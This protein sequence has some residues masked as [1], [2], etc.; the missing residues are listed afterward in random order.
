M[1]KTRG[2]GHAL[3]RVVARGLGEGMVMI[4]TVLPNVEGRPHWHA[5]NEYLSL[6]TMLCLRYLWTHLRDLSVLTEYVDHV[7]ANER[8]ELKLSSHGRKVHNLG[9]PVPAIEDMSLCTDEAMLLLVELLMVSAD[10]AMVETGQCGG[11]YALRDLILAGRYAWGAA[12]LVHMYDQLNNAS[13]STSRQLAVAECNADLDYDE[14]S[15]RTCRWIATKKTV[16][17]VSTTTYRQRLDRLRIPDVCWMPYAE[18]RPMQYF[19]PISCFSGQLRWGLLLSDTDQRGLCASSTTSNAFLHTL[20][21]HRC[22]M[23][24]WTIRGRTTQTIWQQQVIYV[25]CQEACHAIMEALEQHLNAPGTSTH[26]EVI[27]KCLRIARGV[28]EDHNVYVRSRRR[29]HSNQQ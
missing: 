25:L 27:E 12:G 4:L 1:V 21:I 23:M 18:H 15:G 6:L 28:T 24:T 22:H 17:K 5:R 10:V 19:H 11:P 16:K 26:E 13:L 20:S 8:P 9:K 7:A 14:V 2:L 29:R 3:G